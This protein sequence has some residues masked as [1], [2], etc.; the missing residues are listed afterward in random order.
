VVHAQGATVAA[1]VP[2]GGGEVAEAILLVAE[3]VR[4]GEAPILTL[5]GE[6]IGRGAYAASLHVEGAVCPEVG[7]AAIGG[8]REVMIETNRHADGFGVLLYR[9]KLA[10]DGPGQPG[11]KLDQ[12]G[13]FGGEGIDG[14]R[15]R[16]LQFG[17]PLGPDPDVRVSLVQDFV[18]GTVNGIAL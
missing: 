11:V 2:D 18:K 5:R 1:V 12:A 6:T 4:R 10:V 14:R 8:E 7:A 16:V 15:I 3:R 17:G 9:G 13:V